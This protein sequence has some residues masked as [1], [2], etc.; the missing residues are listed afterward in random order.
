MYPDQRPE[1]QRNYKF[2]Y[3]SFK[4]SAR[5][6]YENRDVLPRLNN[7]LEQD[8]RTG[9]DH[10]TEYSP[11]DDSTRSE[12]SDDGESSADEEDG[13]RDLTKDDDILPGWFKAAAQS[14]V[15]IG[16][17]KPHELLTLT[18]ILCQ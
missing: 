4:S 1:F 11:E 18:N 7:Y 14:E 13:L 16:S 3:E 9:A 10:E 6:E 8:W 2:N 12:S 5:M 17:N 15:S